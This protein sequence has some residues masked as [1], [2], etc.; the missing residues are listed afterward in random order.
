MADMDHIGSGFDRGSTYAYPAPIHRPM[1]ICRDYDKLA[2]EYVNDESEP[3]DGKQKKKRL[4]GYRC[5][6]RV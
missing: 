3:D 5:K 1:E 6:S 2:K 4:V